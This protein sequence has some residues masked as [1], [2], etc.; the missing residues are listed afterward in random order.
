MCAD[1]GSDLQQSDNGNTSEASVPMIHSV[2]DL[3]VTKKEAQ[4]LGKADTKRLLEDKKLALLVDLDQTIIHTTNDHVPAN[5]ADVH[6][7][8]LFG[9]NSPWYHT[10][11][12]P[13]TQ[14]FLTEMSQFFELHICTFGARGYA[15]QI[16]KL[17]DPDGKLFA[18]RI[19]SRDECLSIST[20]TENLQ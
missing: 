12:R 20:K 13:G 5:I 9:S 18:Q 4:R 8:Q 11:L 16:A 6:H 7:F 3:K 15:H 2:P 1:C 17:L 10:R 19:L 14:H